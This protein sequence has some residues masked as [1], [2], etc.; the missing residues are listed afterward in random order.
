M[1]VQVVQAVSS[2]SINS[3]EPSTVC[4]Y[5]LFNIFETSKVP[6][7]SQAV[8]LRYPYLVAAVKGYWFKNTGRKASCLS[9]NLYQL[10]IIISVTE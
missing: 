1:S 5:I 6:S 7:K 4:Q 10:P 9:L 3:H 2:T 8:E